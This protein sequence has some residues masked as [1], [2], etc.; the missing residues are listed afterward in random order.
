[1]LR[2]WDTGKF[3]NFIFYFLYSPVI[4]PPTSAVA[5]EEP[6]AAAWLAILALGG[7]KYRIICPR[8]LAIKP[9]FPEGV[10]ACH[11]Q[12]RVQHDIPA[13]DNFSLISY[14]FFETLKSMFTNSYKH[15][16]KKH[17]FLQKWWKYL[18]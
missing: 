7:Q 11:L 9:A 17:L 13:N 18:P 4:S 16:Y 8:C 3:F 2:A 6:S 12:A 10:H 1:M 15:V 14:I 5:M